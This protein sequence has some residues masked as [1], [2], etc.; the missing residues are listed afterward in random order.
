MKTTV[1]LADDHAIF[2][3]G[4]RA[5]IERSPDR[6][7]V[8]EAEDGRSAVNLAGKLRPQIVV[9]DIGMP[10][11]NGIEATRQIVAACDETR[12]IILS[13]HSEKRFI[14]EAFKAGA[15]GYLL[16]DGAFEELERAIA[17][18]VARQTYLSPSIAGSV[19]DVLVDSDR[20]KNGSSAPPDLTP[21]E[22]EVLQLLAE[23]RGIKEIAAR[24][25]LSQK[26]I[27]THRRKVMDKLGIY[28]VAGLVRYAIKAG[29]TSLHF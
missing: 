5:L 26:T 18:V 23:G 24:L 11:L 29:L 3:D 25:H 22:A 8:G 19:V 10:E 17:V 6:E 2:R 21:R 16:K 7:V 4:L 27:E 13:M 20:S 12:V 15:S 9:M 1:L 14:T 28:N